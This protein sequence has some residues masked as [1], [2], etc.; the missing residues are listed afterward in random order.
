LLTEFDGEPCTVLLEDTADALGKGGVTASGLGLNRELYEGVQ[1]LTKR[2]GARRVSGSF[3]STANQ[4]LVLNEV[5]KKDLFSAARLA[6][7][8][9]RC[10]NIVWRTRS[11]SGDIQSGFESLLQVLLYLWSLL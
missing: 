6:A 9:S 3:I 4:H 10:M 11:A 5:M 2:S 1:Q 8:L 7:N